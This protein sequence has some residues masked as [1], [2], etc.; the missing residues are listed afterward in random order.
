MLLTLC[1]IILVAVLYLIFRRYE[2]KA[3][4]KYE[5]SAETLEG[6]KERF[7]SP[8]KKIS[9]LTKLVIAGMA[10]SVGFVILIFD[11]MTEEYWLFFGEN[12]TTQIEEKYG[13]TV[14]YNVDLKK[15]SSIGHGQSGIV[16]KLEFETDLDGLTF[17][18]KNCEGELIK[19]AEADMM[20]YP[21]TSETEQAREPEEYSM[22]SGAVGQYWYKIGNREYIMTFYKDGGSYLVKIY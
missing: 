16:G 17:M 10:V 5:F 21:P 13:L 12:R 19:Y 9:S 8:P 15:Y 4:E 18:Q 2:K 11:A 7:F 3:E 20:Y 1:Y 14:D 22:K 6:R